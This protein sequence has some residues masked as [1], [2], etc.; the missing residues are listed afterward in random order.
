M[1]NIYIRYPSSSFTGSVTTSEEAVAADGGALPSKVKVVAG[2]DGTNVQVLSTDVNGVL[3]VSGTFSEEATAADG[4]SLP[5]KVKVV[6]GY[7]GTNVQVISTDATG[8]LNIN[9]IS[10]AISLPTGAATEYTLNQLATSQLGTINSSPTP[11]NLAANANF[12]SSWI[13]TFYY[14]CL[15]VSIFS[16]VSSA[17]DGVKLEFSHDAISLHKYYTYTYTGGAGESYLVNPEFKYFRI[18]YTN[19]SSAQTSFKIAIISR[20]QTKFPSLKRV[21]SSTTNETQALITKSVITGESS[22]SP[23]SFVNVK[24]NSS[25]ALKSDVTGTVAATQ[26]GT[27]NVTDVSGTVSLPTGASTEAT[28]SSLNGKVTA[29]NTGAVTVASS[30]LPTGAATSA[31]QPG[32]GTAGTSSSDVLT[33]QGIA[34]MTALKVDGSAVTQPVSGTVS[35]T[36]ES[37]IDLVDGDIINCA[38]TTINGSSGALVPIVTS[39]AAN[40]YKLQILDTTGGFIGIYTGASG[41]EVLKLVSGPGSDQTIQHVIPVGTRISVKRLDSTTA[42]TSGIYAINFIG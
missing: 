27:W 41:S 30:A 33:V 36:A 8:A 14:G 28:L 4:G 35:I 38:T 19:G 7:D 13:S 34:G 10:G 11:S 40:C 31:K 18:N 22:S 37:V 24:V 3:N 23:G 1:S 32:L 9:K 15:E 6:G 16:D 12:T 42:L 39:L 20:A 21:S 25:G 26:S 5:A 2:Y 17:I 29:C